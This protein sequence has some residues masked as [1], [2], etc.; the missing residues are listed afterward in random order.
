M[1][2]LTSVEHSFPYL[3]Y[4]KILQN[5]H[6]TLVLEQES[7]TIPQTWSTLTFCHPSWKKEVSFVSEFFSFGYQVQ[8]IFNFG[9]T[10]SNIYQGSLILY[11]LCIL[12]NIQMAA[13]S[14]MCNNIVQSVSNIN[15]NNSC[16]SNLHNNT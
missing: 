15:T 12:I 8:M 7:S 10:S 3:S 6:L 9:G 16:I 13:K 1:N 14:N 4:I 2:N 11:L 5:S